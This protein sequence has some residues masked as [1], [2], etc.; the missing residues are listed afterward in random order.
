MP[1]LH[2]F[3]L[4]N[5]TLHPGQRDV[6][7]ELFERA[8][9]ESQEAL[10]AHVLGTFRNL[11]DPNRFVWVRGFA[12]FAARYDALN[13]FY[14]GPVWQAHRNTANATMVDSDDVLLL[15]P[16]AGSLARY[17][18]TRPTVGATAIPESLII[19]TTYF[20]RPYG[21]EDFA[22][23]FARDAAPHLLETGADLIAAFATE[24]SANNFPR[25][26]VRENETVFVSFA[27]FASSAAFA[28][29]LAALHAWPAWRRIEDDLQR[30]VVAPTEILR[31]QPTAR[32]LL[33]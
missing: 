2:V 16:V 9:V 1:P 25:L 10:G 6:L 22:A 4:R 13:D 12:D 31:L 17:P 29:H 3:E 11:D 7:I 23:F 5:Y 18:A 15:R 8:F 24:H 30:R 14:S 28:A 19:A 27:R 20:L 21:D 32:S 33:R 26:P